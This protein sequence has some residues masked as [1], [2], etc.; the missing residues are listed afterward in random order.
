MIIK[1]RRLSFILLAVIMCFSF[2]SCRTSDINNTITDSTPQTEIPIIT[3]TETEKESISSTQDEITTLP[4]TPPPFSVTE[5]YSYYNKVNHLYISTT[6][7]IRVK[8]NGLIQSPSSNGTGTHGGHESR[9][10]RTEHG[11]YAVYITDNRKDDSYGFSWDE[12]TVFKLNDNDFDQVILKDEYPHSDGSCAPNILYGSDGKLYVTIIADDK[13][14]YFSNNFSKEGAWIKIYTIDPIT[15]EYEVEHFTPDFRKIWV[16]GYGYSQPILDCENQ[17]LYTLYTG[18]DVP[19][20]LVWF[21]FDLQTKKWDYSC[22]TFENDFRIAYFNAYPDGNGGFYFFGERAVLKTGLEEYYDISFADP[23][24][25]IWDALY[26]CHVKDPTTANVDIRVIKEAEYESG[27][28]DVPQT[29]VVHYGCGASYRDSNGVTHLVYSYKTPEGTDVYYERYSD[30]LELIES[31]EIN[32]TDPS[33]FFT[34]AIAE[35]SNG[36]YLIISSTLE[37]TEHAKLEIWHSENNGDSFSLLLDPTYLKTNQKRVCK[38]FYKLSFSSTRNGSVTDG[39]V[40]LLF[41]DDNNYY[42]HF[43]V[44]LPNQ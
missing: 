12:F 40:D 4:A 42:Y 21:I 3:P 5:P 14:K 33:N 16:H 11:V 34:I 10:V 8:K 9:I 30:E 22:Y 32:F 37:N 2:T 28:K 17:K 36:L 24:G 20:Y 41:F 38:S 25:Y 35:N 7:S 39:R 27:M 19:G 6:E 13:Y 18:G 15:F 44:V 43:H 23:N 1:S 29:G 26:L 31:R